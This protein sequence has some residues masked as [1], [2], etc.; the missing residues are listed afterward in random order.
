MLSFDSTAART[1]RVRVLI[2]AAVLVCGGAAAVYLFWPRSGSIPDDPPP[3]PRLAGDVQYRNVR[4]DVVY[5]GDAACA[6]CHA[7]ICASYHRHPMG[8][9]AARPDPAVP[10]AQFTAFGNVQYRV[11]VRDGKVLHT[12]VIPGADGQPASVTAA[13]VMAVIG[14]GTRGKSYLCA[15]DGSLWQSGVSW[16]SEKPGWDASPAFWPGRH[17]RRAVQPECLFCH[18]NRAEPVSGTNNRYK[19][20]VFGDQFAIGCERCH[21]P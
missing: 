6:P 8:R 7:S 9:S 16:F 21:G 10:S 5:L 13:E 2:A 17:A 3:D 14:S 12:E 20:P 18:V 15:R 11:E 19:E 1:A 4:P